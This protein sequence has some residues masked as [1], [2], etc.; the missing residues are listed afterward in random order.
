MFELI[1]GKV[2]NAILTAIIVAPVVNWWNGHKKRKSDAIRLKL[3]G[4]KRVR[5]INGGSILGECLLSVGESEMLTNILYNFDCSDVS[6]TEARKLLQ[7]VVS[8][9]GERTNQTLERV[10]T[11]K[12]GDFEIEL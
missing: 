12:N 8:E 4:G 2:V 1:A 6:E 10:T 7:S 5:V 9:F 11:I 3:Y